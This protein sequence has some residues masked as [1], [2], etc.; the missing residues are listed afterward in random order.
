MNDDVRDL[1]SAMLAISYAAVLLLLGELYITSR[2]TEMPAIS[3]QA[4]RLDAAGVLS[5]THCGLAYP[6]WSGR[7]R[8]TYGPRPP[9]RTHGRR[10][11]PIGLSFGLPHAKSGASIAA[12]PI[13][14]LISA[15]PQSFENGHRSTSSALA[16]LS[17]RV[18]T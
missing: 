17:V 8:R 3:H 14:E 15:L 7:R 11:W 6:R 2:S 9:N 10:G 18:P 5:Y 1:V 12:C 16:P 13:P 4:E